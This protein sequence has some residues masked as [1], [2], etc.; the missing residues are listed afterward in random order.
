MDI[1]GQRLRERA[2]Q[3]GISNAEAGRRAGLD[4]RR[5]A[6]YAN[7]RREPDLATLVKIAGALHTTPDWLL[8]IDREHN[9]TSE[10]ADL[11]GRL[12]NSASGLPDAELRRL[13]VLAEALLRDAEKSTESD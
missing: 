7:G 12:L 8:G 1:F 9:G 13:C 5:Y 4:E 10:R 11:L 3:L 2:E 6:H